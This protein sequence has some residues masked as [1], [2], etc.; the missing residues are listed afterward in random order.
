MDTELA[1]SMTFPECITQASLPISLC[2]LFPPNS[3]RDVVGHFLGV[4]LYLFPRNF[5]GGLKEFKNIFLRNCKG[6]NVTLIQYLL[7]RLSLF[8]L[9]NSFYVI[10]NIIKHIIHNFIIYI[11]I[12]IIYHTDSSKSLASQCYYLG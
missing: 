3:Y 8:W 9:A 6:G 11:Y 2:S 7:Q 1:F 4:A 5:F 12:Y 10:I